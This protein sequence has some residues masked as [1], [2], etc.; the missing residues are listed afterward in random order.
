MLLSYS[1]R[2]QGC[3]KHEQSFNGRGDIAVM[4]YPCREDYRGNVNCYGIRDCCGGS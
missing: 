3:D 2:K 4:H 1:T